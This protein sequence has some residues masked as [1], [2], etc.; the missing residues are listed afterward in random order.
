MMKQCSAVANK[1]MNVKRTPCR[2]SANGIRRVN[3]VETRF[4]ASSPYFPPYL[5]DKTTSVARGMSSPV[6]PY[7]LIYS[8]EGTNK[9]LR[10]DVECTPLATEVVSLWIRSQIRYGVA[11]L[12]DTR[13]VNPVETHCIASSQFWGGGRGRAV[14]NEE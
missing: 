13:P 12:N 8:M 10:L 7:Y 4:I 5:T 3:P 6:Q 2:Q 9:G 14:L 1:V 11:G